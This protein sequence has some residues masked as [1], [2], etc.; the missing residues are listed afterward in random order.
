MITG[1][2]FLIETFFQVSSPDELSDDPFLC[3]RIQFQD[4][5]A[6]YFIALSCVQL[7]D[8]EVTLVPEMPDTVG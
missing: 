4:L 1:S 2:A 5:L 8:R 6:D 3:R 7:R